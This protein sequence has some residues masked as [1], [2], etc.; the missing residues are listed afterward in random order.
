[1]NKIYVVTFLVGSNENIF[2]IFESLES[3][4][5]QVERW[6][7]TNN[8]SATKHVIKDLIVYQGYDGGD[9]VEL[10]IEGVYPR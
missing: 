5:S 9:T 6:F 4:V 3:A 7:Y 8:I 10:I 1:M 2:G